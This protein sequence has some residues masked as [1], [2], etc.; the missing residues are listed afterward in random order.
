M[1]KLFD[2]PV[3]LIALILLIVLLFGAKR[4]PDVAR[5][6]GSSMKIFKK[7]VKDL[8]D[9]EDDAPRQAA[10][11]PTPTTTDPARPTEPQP[12]TGTPTSAGSTSGDAAPQ[13][14]GTTDPKNT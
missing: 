4:L 8:R 1:A 10:A 7:E 6:V 9:D 14:G 13:P 11:N 2:N 5:S 3:A 12:P